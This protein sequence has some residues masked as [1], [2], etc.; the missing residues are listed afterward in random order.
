MAL[1]GSSQKFETLADQSCKLAVYFPIEF[2]KKVLELD[3][4]EMM[5][6][7]IEEYEALMSGEQQA[8]PVKFITGLQTLDEALE[9]VQA[10]LSDLKDSAKEKK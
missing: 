8:V 10:I 3:G 1:K 9:T 2:K 4:G 5:C 6:M 7:N